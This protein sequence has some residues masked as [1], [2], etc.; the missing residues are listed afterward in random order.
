MKTLMDNCCP[1]CTHTPTA[2]C[3]SYIA[4]RTAGPLCHSNDECKTKI[5]NHLQRILAP[6]G[7]TEQQILTCGGTGCQSAG[8]AQLAAALQEALAE[9][10]MTAAVTVK[11][12][13]CHGFCEQGPIVHIKPADIFYTRVKPTDARAIVQHLADGKILERLV[14]RDSTGRPYPRMAEIPFYAG[15]TMLLLSRCGHI[16]PEQIADYVATGGYRSLT[17]VLQHMTPEQVIEEISLSG[18]RGRGGA[19]FPTGKKW[20]AARRA[21]GDIKYIICNADEGDPGAFMDRSLLEG[22]PHA[23]LEGMLIAGFATGSRQGYIYCR[24]EYPLAIKRLRI[25]VHQARQWGL[26][27]SNIL[28]SGFSFDIELKEGAGAFVCGEGTAL[29]ASIEGLRGMPRVKPPRST[30]KGLWDKPTVLNNVETLANVPLIIQL[31]AAAYRQLGTAQSPGTKI[32]A[33]SGAL[34][35]PGLVE[36]PMGKTLRQIIF[37]I[38][39]GIRDGKSFKAVQLGGPSGGCLTG[40]HLDLPVDFDSLSS[41]GA[42]IG[43]GGMVVMAEDTCMVDVARFFLAFTQQESCGKCTPCREGTMRMLEILERI[44]RGEAEPADLADLERL[45]RV[46]KSTSLCGLGQACANPVLSTLQYFRAE[47]MAHIVEKRCPAG[48]CSSLVRYS[49]DEKMCRGCG[50]C[51]KSCPVNAVKGERKLPHVID[52]SRCVKCGTCLNSCKFKAVVKA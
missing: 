12:T 23:V 30:E 50:L 31:G 3:S 8:S 43:S 17:R 32:F 2:P 45:C 6:S 51:L 20:Q 7:G 48:V 36:V 44:C 5:Q 27:G 9:T 28:N 18:L 29:Q 41:L 4:C 52:Q 40:Q 37:D 10:G 25:A 13:G 39:G 33:L 49:I 1:A 35:N 42:T 14:Y 24:A 19:G 26:L 16:D 38:G 34:A 46:V 21:A 22:D 47:Y 15:Q 11:I